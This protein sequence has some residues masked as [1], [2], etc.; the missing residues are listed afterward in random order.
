MS[1]HIY[2]MSIHSSVCSPIILS[3]CPLFCPSVNPTVH[4]Y[5]CN[6]IVKFAKS[7][8][9]SSEINLK[10]MIQFNGNRSLIKW[11]NIEKKI[12]FKSRIV[13]R[14]N[15]FYLIYLLSVHKHHFHT[16]LILTDLYW[17]LNTAFLNRPLFSPESVM[18]GYRPNGNVNFRL[19]TS[20]RICG[21]TE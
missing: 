3:V 12:A 17:S 14:T 9:K 5:N 16:Q 18:L 10:W 8:T 7:K 19:W 2:C 15:L 4:P 20:L 1:M 21:M 11:K 13:V 6:H